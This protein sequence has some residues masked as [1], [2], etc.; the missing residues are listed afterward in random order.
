MAE[1]P[2]NVLILAEDNL[3]VRLVPDQKLPE[4]IALP[5][6]S[7]MEIKKEEFANQ[8][9]WYY[10]TYTNLEKSSVRDTSGY[11]EVAP[12]LKD[13]VPIK[14]LQN[15]YLY[16]TLDPPT[17]YRINLLDARWQYTDE[18]Y[19]QKQSGT[20]SADDEEV[21]KEWYKIRCQIFL[22]SLEEGYI[23]TDKQFYRAFNMDDA[24]RRVKAVQ[25]NA[26]WEKVLKEKILGGFI[27]ERMTMDMVK[28]SWGEPRKIEYGS[29][30]MWL[31]G[32]VAE[33]VRVKFSKGQ[34][35]DWDK[36]E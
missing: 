25:T 10:V 26:G 1:P 9:R 29:P 16:F 35:I 24:E 3:G 36:K 21:V 2:K 30:Q 34:V 20:T 27:S 33:P 17:K 8:Y 11:I 6:L 18:I 7:I 28:A 13:V 4:K 15:A 23:P 22:P 19:E 12:D 31:Y 14:V 32:T 5:R